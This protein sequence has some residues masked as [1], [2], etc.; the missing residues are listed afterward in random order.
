MKDVM[1]LR[2]DSIETLQRELREESGAY[3]KIKTQRA[4]GQ[5]RQTHQY[6]QMR[7]QLARMR[8]ILAEKLAAAGD[9]S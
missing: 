6:R 4:A 1:Q 7:R 9:E 2:E 3:F 5:L 8:T